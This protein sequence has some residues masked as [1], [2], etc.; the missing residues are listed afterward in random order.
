MIGY[1]IEA[2]QYSAFGFGPLPLGLESPVIT[3]AER[4]DA[5]ILM[6][7]IPSTSILSRNRIVWHRSR[8]GMLMSTAARG[9][10]VT[11]PIR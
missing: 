11:N 3:R 8:A 1:H 7:N 2:I 10:V 4:S 6:V 9:G 5:G